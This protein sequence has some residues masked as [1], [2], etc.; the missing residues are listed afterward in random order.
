MLDI[1]VRL[2]GTACLSLCALF[3][4]VAVINKDNRRAVRIALAVQAT[5]FA[6]D[7]LGKLSWKTYDILRC[8]TVLA[9]V[10][11]LSYLSRLISRLN[12]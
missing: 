5:Y 9:P 10:V 8:L 4:I 11:V 7:I 12:I 3:F 6:L 1:P 2:Y